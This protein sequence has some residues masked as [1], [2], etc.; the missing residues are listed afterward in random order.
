MKSKVN[1]IAISY[2]G[3]LKRNL[4]P[5]I[6]SSRCAAELAF[7][8]WNKNNIELQE[9]FKIILLNNANKVKGIYELSNGGITGTLVDVRIGSVSSTLSASSPGG[10]PGRRKF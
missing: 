9:T 2:S 1:E 7:E 8:Q 3:S 4:L 10:T 6:T 5:K